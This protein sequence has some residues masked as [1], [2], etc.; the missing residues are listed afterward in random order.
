MAMRQESPPGR[1]YRRVGHADLSAVGEIRAALRDF[2]RCRRRPEETDVAE[3][4]LSE[5]VTNALIHTRNGAVVTV[6]SMAARLRVEVRDFTAGQEPAPYVPNADDGTHG[7][8]LLLVQSLA[9]SWGVTAKALGKVVWFELN[10]VT[11]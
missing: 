5:L 1:L 11:P 6:T 8:G 9:D 2:L 7:R 3:L 10:V 4:L